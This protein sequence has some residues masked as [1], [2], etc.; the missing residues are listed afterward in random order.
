MFC[1]CAVLRCVVL[2]CVVS[3]L[4]SIKR[5]M[6]HTDQLAPAQDP[7]VC[8]ELDPEP[9]FRACSV[10]YMLLNRD[11]VTLLL[12]S[13]TGQSAA[14]KSQKFFLRPSSA[15]VTVNFSSRNVPITT[16]STPKIDA[17]S[18]LDL[19]LSLVVDRILSKFSRTGFRRNQI[20]ASLSLSRWSLLSPIRRSSSSRLRAFALLSSCGYDG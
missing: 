8:L 20:N 5:P 12:V 7:F 17:L 16:S 9:L 13:S 1:S 11:P 15:A 14:R 3:S 18:L 10:R 4:G 2:C 19:T 6:T